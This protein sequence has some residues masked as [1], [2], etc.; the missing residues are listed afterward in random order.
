MSRKRSE[1]S[2]DFKR[3]LDVKV[4]RKHLENS[5]ITDTL[6]K[7]CPDKRYTSF[8]KVLIFDHEAFMW[9][10][11]KIASF[12]GVELKLN[13]CPTEKDFSHYNSKTKEISLCVFYR[14]YS[15]ISRLLK[16]FC[17]E[18]G[19]AIQNLEAGDSHEMHMWLYK[20]HDRMLKYERAAERLAYFLYDE[21]F[22]WIRKLK[23]QG[24]SAYRTKREKEL[25]RAY[26]D[27]IRTVLRGGDNGKDYQH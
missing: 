10:A 6:Q 4:L 3:V 26:L 27:K 1:N 13:R 16:V 20:S 8:M 11:G 9:Y 25:L 7:T 15:D 23:H 21:H 19:H 12:Y 14:D 5:T 18:L 22:S 17:H 24:F 2:R